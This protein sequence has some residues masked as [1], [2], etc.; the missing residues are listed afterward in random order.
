[1]HI[2]P[3]SAIRDGPLY[4]PWNHDRDEAVPIRDQSGISRDW[5][6]WLP[7]NAAIGGVIPA[8][9]FHADNV[10]LLGRVLSMGL[11]DKAWMKSGL[12]AWLSGRVARASNPPRRT[13]V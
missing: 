7:K 6:Q 11:F 12:G 13:E 9:R 2:I 5:R 1:M 4:G 8:V 3:R 10:I